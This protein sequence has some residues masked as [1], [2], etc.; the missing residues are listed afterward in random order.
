[1]PPPLP[2]FCNIEAYEK[3]IG[4]LGTLETNE[5]LL[6]ASVAISMHF[7]DGSRCESVGWSIAALADSILNRVTSRSQDA[8]LAHIHE[9]LFDQNGFAGNSN[10][11]Y[12]IDNS[13]L[14]IVL[15]TGLGIPITLT[16]V[17][18]LVAEEVGLRVEGINS[19]GHF[20]ARVHLSPNSTMIVDPFH[21]GRILTV[22][23]SLELVSGVSHVDPSTVAQLLPT[24]THR[25]WLARI[26]N[27]LQSVLLNQS[28]FDDVSAMRELLV[29]LIEP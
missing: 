9:V 22:A 14:P 6:N 10:N 2:N 18:K 20:L 24:C 17:Y 16:L 25:Q 23:E 21:G 13:L 7:L 19:P 3:F 27:N 1:M 11:Y 4:C 5:S 8:L 15:E 12:E 29:A 26:L 28:R